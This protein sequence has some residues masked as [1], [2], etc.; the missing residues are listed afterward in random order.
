MV[1][2]L[3][4][5]CMLLLCAG[6]VAG[7]AAIDNASM[8][9]GAGAGTVP[10]SLGQNAVISP[11][12][13]SIVTVAPRRDADREVMTLHVHRVGEP[14]RDL[15][16]SGSGAPSVSTTKFLRGWLDDAT[17]AY[18][19]HVGTGA[20]QLFLLD[21]NT[22]ERIETE[23]L[24]ATRFHVSATGRYIA[25]QWIGGPPSFW[26]WDRVDAQMIDLPAL[27][28]DYQLIEDWALSGEHILFSAWTGAW[29]ADAETI[30]NYYVLSMRSGVVSEHTAVSN[31]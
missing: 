28:G 31:P 25:G 19:E 15:L 8:D 12:G 26:V 7:S 5:F 13:K 30:S 18:E 16:P 27:P 24:T 3:G 29:P 4:I 1:R 2:I 14:P 6:C 10:A 20:R 9:E 22:W 17:L 23:P 21:S 11:D